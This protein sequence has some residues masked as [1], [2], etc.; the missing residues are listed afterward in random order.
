MKRRRA[1][2]EPAVCLLLALLLLAGRAGA[3]YEDQPRFEPFP[4]RYVSAGLN[5]EVFSPLGTNPIPDSLA[6]RFHR[7]MPMLAYHQGL[8]DIVFGYAA[9]QLHGQSRSSVIFSTTVANELSLTG[10]GQHTLLVPIVLAAD[11]TKAEA[12]GGLRDNFNIGSIGLGGGLRYRF[13]SPGVEF[14]IRGLEIA[15]FCFEGFGVGNGFSA[16]TLGEASLLL[17][18]IPVADGLVLGY[19]F[20]QQTW[21]MS[22]RTFR[23]RSVS[24]GPYLGVM[25]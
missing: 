12:L 6:I 4:S 13:V 24:H 19:R 5:G 18:E 17:K 25:F 14:S 15:H 21:S 2:A 20:R 22:D 9:Y 11:F 10:R 8:V 1:C 16:A 7:L 23:Y 3:Q